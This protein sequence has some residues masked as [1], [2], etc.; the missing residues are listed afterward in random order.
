MPGQLPPS[1]PGFPW[2]IPFSTCRIWG[3]MASARVYLIW[4][5]RDTAISRSH[6]ER[7]QIQSAHRQLFIS[8]RPPTLLVLYTTERTA[9]SV[10]CEY[11]YPSLADRSTYAGWS[12]VEQRGLRADYRAGRGPTLQRLTVDST[13]TDPIRGRFTDA[14]SCLDLGELSCRAHIV[15]LP[16]YCRDLLIRQTIHNAVATHRP[17][18]APLITNHMPEI[19]RIM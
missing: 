3:K 15:F 17:A 16:C 19:F 1:P 9:V 6:S 12:W 7:L 10:F 4:R 18:A 2:E 8:A 11:E 5:Q 13:T 14:I